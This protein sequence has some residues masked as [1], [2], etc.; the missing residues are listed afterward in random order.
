MQ[1]IAV[2]KITN[3]LDAKFY[4]GIS[5]D[6]Q[7][8]WSTH[9]HRRVQVAKS[10]LYA[11]MSKH[12]VNNFAFTIIHWCTSRQEANELEHFLIDW[13]G[14]NKTGYNI[15]EGGDS[16]AH[17]E[18]TKV[19]IGL[20]G[21]GREVS[22]ETR[23]KISLGLIG[24]VKKP[25]SDSTK[26][27]LSILN[28]GKTHSAETITKITKASVGRTYPNRKKMPL[29]SVLQRAITLKNT[30]AKKAK[31][32]ICNETKEIFSNQT[33]AAKKY[34]LSIGA[35]SLHCNGKS[36]MSKKGYTFSYLINQY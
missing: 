31:A 2:Y 34:G 28:K 18:E 3:L 24:R 8:R 15:R 19:K 12:G 33:Q 14:T 4:I 1:P 27:K 26:L 22:L 13:C 23:K 25:L 36:T 10:K 29:D 5:V 30:L 16:G 7:K 17:S 9:K 6:P 11:A 21:I 35:V 32:V 20:I